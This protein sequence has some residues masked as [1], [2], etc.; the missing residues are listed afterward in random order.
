MYIP[1]GGT[2]FWEAITNG[3]RAVASAQRLLD[4]I[5]TGDIT[6]ITGADATGDDLIIKANDVDDY[7]KIRMYGNGSF[8][9]YTAAQGQFKFYSSTTQYFKVDATSGYYNIQIKETGTSPSTVSGFGL[10][11]TKSDNNLYFRD[12]DGTEH[13]VA[14]V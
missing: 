5:H 12:G 4:I 1:S 14:F 7:C 13:T 11:Y 2:G 8:N 9:L 10:I 3:I 6:Y